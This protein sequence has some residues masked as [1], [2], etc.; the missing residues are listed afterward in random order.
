MGFG[1]VDLVG[2]FDLENI[3]GF[4][5]Q[6]PPLFI[7]EVCCGFPVSNHF[8][9]IIYTYGPMVCGQHHFDVQ[10]GQFLQKIIEM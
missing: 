4:I 7:P 1:E 6:I 9:R 10:F 5:I 2:I 3:L 8:H